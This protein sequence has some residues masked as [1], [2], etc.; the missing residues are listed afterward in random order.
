MWLV[1]YISNMDKRDFKEQIKRIAHLAR[2][3]LT[4]QEEELYASQLQNI[5]DYFEKLQELNTEEVEPMAHVLP[6]SNVWREDES[7][8]DAISS[9]KDLFQNAPEVEDSLFKIPRILKKED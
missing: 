6:L 1:T 9:K 8:E 7:K 5:L 4:P 2:L 3:F